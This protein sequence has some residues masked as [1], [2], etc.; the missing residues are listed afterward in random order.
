MTYVQLRQFKIVDRLLEE[1]TF[2]AS[3]EAF[4]ITEKLKVSRAERADRHTSHRIVEK[5]MIGCCSVNR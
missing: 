4:P 5:L 3:G 2:T 1:R